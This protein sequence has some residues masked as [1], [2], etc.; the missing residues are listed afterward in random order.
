MCWFAVIDSSGQPSD[1][2]F[3]ITALLLKEE[4]I[5]RVRRE[6]DRVKLKHNLGSDVEIHAKELFHG[7]GFF[8]EIRDLDERITIAKDVL[9]I[10]D[11]L[12]PLPRIVTALGIGPFI[13]EYEALRTGLTY[14]LERVA[15]AFDKLSGKNELLV[16]LI[17][18]ST[19]KR[20]K[21]T[22][23][24][25]NNVVSKGDYASKWPVSRRIISRPIFMDSR[26][27][28]AIQLVDLIA[29]IIRRV[30]SNKRTIAGRDLGP[31]YATIE[32]YL[33]RCRDGRIEGCGI[34]FFKSEK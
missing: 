17:D 5:L 31:L 11:K 12:Q 2:L 13:E 25:I 10:L 14:L 34:K 21:V 24:L 33:D 6:I 16:I 23:L 8:S 27:E 20:D 19:Y 1:K 32:R 30:H 26:R 18:E 28:A 4:H 22:S 9:A 15:I 7:K 29:Y 3:V